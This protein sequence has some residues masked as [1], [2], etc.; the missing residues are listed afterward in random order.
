[1]NS[2]VKISIELS[3]STFMLF[4]SKGFVL[5]ISKHA[6]LFLFLIPCFTFKMFIYPTSACLCCLLPFQLSLIVASFLDHFYYEFNLLDLFCGNPKF[7]IWT[8]VVA[9]QLLSCVRLFVTPWT[10]AWQASLSITISGSLPKLMS[11]KSVMPSNHLILCCPLLLLPSIFPS[12]RV[13]S[14]ELALRIRWP[15]YW[16]YQ[17]VLPMNI[18][19]LFPLDLYPKKVYT[20]FCWESEVTA[21]LGHYHT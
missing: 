4:M 12:I 7:L 8:F 2:V 21:K 6:S 3:I 19:G 17:S 18:Q 5:I 14:N 9:V 10:A 15:K 13:F 1:M 11:I 20:Y 16:S